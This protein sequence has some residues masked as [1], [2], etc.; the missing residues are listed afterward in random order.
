M[1]IGAGK[2]VGIPLAIT[3]FGCYLTY[4]L[5]IRAQMRHDLSVSI[6]RSDNG[7]EESEYVGF[8]TVLLGPIVT[9]GIPPTEFYYT[10]LIRN[11]GD[12]PEEAL[13]TRIWFEVGEGSAPAGSGLSLDAS[14]ELLLQSA[15]L[16]A[17]PE[18][19][20]LFQLTVSRLNPREW[21]SLTSTWTAPV[22][23]NIEAR[24]KYVSSG[25]SA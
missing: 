7:T 4:R 10:G 22:R 17:L 6:S 5:S 24:S 23:V 3:A 11:D 9:P 21:L 18:R 15:K 12:F 14:S 16:N 1:A 13:A 25:G 8:E 2:T 19:E 20:W